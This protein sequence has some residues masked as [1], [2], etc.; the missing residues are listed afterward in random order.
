MLAA[1]LGGAALGA[2]VKNNYPTTET[3]LKEL[4]QPQLQNIGRW[5]INLAVKYPNRCVTTPLGDLKVEI[6]CVAESKLIDN[7]NAL[8]EA[9]MPISR[10]QLEPNATFYVNDWQSIKI[11]G[12]YSASGFQLISPAG[13]SLAQNLLGTA[14]GWNATDVYSSGFSVKDAATAGLDTSSAAGWVQ[15]DALQPI[16]SVATAKTIVKTIPSTIAG[17]NQAFND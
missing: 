15:N 1:T 17:I 16:S 3:G 6:S 13:E 8:V 11:N 5:V 10:G 9:A 4:I 2:C 14:K 12:Q 7:Q